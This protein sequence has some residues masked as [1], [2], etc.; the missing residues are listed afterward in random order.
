MGLNLIIRKIHW[1]VRQ[2][3]E[4]GWEVGWQPLGGHWL[5]L[6]AACAWRPCYEDGAYQAAK[7]ERGRPSP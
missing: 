3:G 2:W 6:P 7:E 5:P 1:P 4:G